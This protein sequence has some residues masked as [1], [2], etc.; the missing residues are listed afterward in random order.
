M[1][2]I[3]ALIWLV[4]LLTELYQCKEE[5]SFALAYLVL[6]LLRLADPTSVQSNSVRHQ[7]R[8]FPNCTT[9]DYEG[10]AMSCI[11]PSLLLMVLQDYFSSSSAIFT[12]LPFGKLSLAHSIVATFVWEPTLQQGFFVAVSFLSLCSAAC[13]WIGRGSW[14]LVVPTTNDTSLS[15]A[16]FMLF[17]VVGMALKSTLHRSV[18]KGEWIVASS[19]V[20]LSIVV[21][22]D[23]IARQ[24]NAIEEPDLYSLTATVGLFG[25]SMSCFGSNLIE[26]RFI[27]LRLLFVAI[28]TFGFIEICF[29]A[30]ESTVIY[31]VP[32]CLFW[33][34]RDFLME[35]ENNSS[36]WTLPQIPRVGWLG[37]W[38]GVMVCTL[39][40]APSSRRNPVISRKWFHLVA[41]VL[42]VPTTLAA[43]KLQSLSYAIALCVLMVLETIR[44]Q[45]PWLNAFYKTYLD[46]SKDESEDSTVVSHVGLVLGCAV[47]LWLHQWLGERYTEDDTILPLIGV[48]TLGIGDAMGAVVGKTF[49]RWKWG[50]QNRTVEGSLAMFASISVVLFPFGN[51]AVW[52][53]SV[54]AVTVL[55]AWTLQIDNILLPLVSSMVILMCSRS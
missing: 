51:L 12:A 33:M 13:I 37:Y 10:T 17:G 16:Y 34:F 55:E 6:H 1:R 35:T 36:Q 30:Q 7:W 42:F 2:N 8:R 38:F 24:W 3:E 28:V 25:C 5:R 32:R 20:A 27:F 29:Q 53:P 4:F 39:P 23:S 45:L 49:G 22:V 11:L 19:L 48:W 50:Q 9:G 43:P 46:S 44:R 14:S 52:L 15:L 21:W 31:P 26:E 54:V 18:T 41:V 47:P 40:L